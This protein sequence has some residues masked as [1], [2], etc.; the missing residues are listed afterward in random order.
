MHLDV[1]SKASPFPK[2]LQGGHHSN[3]SF[4]KYGL[5]Y[6]SYGGPRLGEKKTMV[7]YFSTQSHL[8]GTVPTVGS[9]Y[10]SQ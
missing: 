8:N 9:D 7:L 10:P 1:S 4:P 6:T 3:I 5:G 2:R